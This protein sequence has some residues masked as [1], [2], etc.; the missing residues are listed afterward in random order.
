M[1]DIQNQAADDFKSQLAELGAKLRLREL[2]EERERILSAFPSLR[3]V[4]A[5]PRSRRI[6]DEKRRAM[7]EGMKHYWAQVKARRGEQVG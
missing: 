2:E 3:D 1:A 4:T 6:S 7:S 5:K